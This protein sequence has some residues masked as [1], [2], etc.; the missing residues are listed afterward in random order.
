MKAAAEA[1]ERAAEAAEGADASQAAEAPNRA[2]ERVLVLAPR[3]RNAEMIAGALRS[4]GFHIDICDGLDQLCT[5][6]L[7]PSG[8]VILCEEALTRTGLDCLIGTLAR[9][10]PW[11]D[12]PLLLLT[13]GGKTTRGSF[14][15]AK[16]LGPRGNVTLMERPV[17]IITLISA[18]RTALRSR[19]R[20]YEVRDLLAREQ[21]ARTSAEAASHAKDHFLATLS[22]ELRT[23]LNPVLMTITAMAQDNELPERYREDVDLVKRNIELESKLIDDLLDLTRIARGKLELHSDAIDMHALLDH[24]LKTCCESHIRRKRLRITTELHAESR[25]VWGDGA[26]LSQ[27]FWNLIKNAVKFT[28]EGGQ[29]TLRSEN[30]DEGSLVLSVKDTGIGIEPAA[31]GRIFDAFE[32]ESRGITRRYGGLGLG[33]AICKALVELHGGNI[34]V[35][36]EGKDKGSTFTVRLTTT[37]EPR[38]APQVKPPSGGNGRIDPLSVLLVEDHDTTA[39]VTSRLLGTLGYKVV[40]AGDIESAKRLTDEQRFD[41]V[42][43]DLG[44]PDGTGIDLLQY[45]RARH[46]LPAIAVSGYGMEDDQQQTKAAGFI[47]HLIKPIDL[48]KLQAAI[49]RALGATAVADKDR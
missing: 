31:A 3:G 45:V 8:A 44:L 48:P 43:S 16:A 39:R 10:A 36:S 26:R 42:V 9:Q 13:G 11:S 5:E 38:P 33:L 14:H 6:M 25:F 49:S 21:H 4:A 37:G 30:D 12:I 20:Q 41:I 1:P 2:D 47:E 40:V 18:V 19:R 24:A 32:Q 22:H 46:N 7:D 29:I 28:P 17:R 34:S 23:P 15:I 35:H 27:V